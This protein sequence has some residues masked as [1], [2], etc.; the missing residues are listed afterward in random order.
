M[1]HDGPREKTIPAFKVSEQMHAEISRR[2]EK[3]TRTITLEV[4]EILKHG[5]SESRDIESRLAALEQV[6]HGDQRTRAN[7]KKKP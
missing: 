3:N 5:L 7:D 2:A 4:I 6:I 1:A